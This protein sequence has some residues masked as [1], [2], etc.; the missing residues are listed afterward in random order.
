MSWY[1]KYMQVYEKPYDEV[2]YADIVS[3]VRVNLAKLQ[4]EHP[5]VT[6]SVIAYNEEKHLLACLWALS[7]LN[8]R[9]PIEIIGVDND[10]KDRTRDVFRASG[11]PY[12]IELQHSCGYARS[13]GLAHA[14]GKY[15]VNIDADT[16][17]PPEYVDR[18]IDIMEHNS[19]VVGVCLQ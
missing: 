6:V 19:E 11:I 3:E 9:Y 1:E 17:Y 15:H 13:C 5:L 7:E 2:A 14:H 4:S 18:I 8:T 10:S 16:L 12:Y